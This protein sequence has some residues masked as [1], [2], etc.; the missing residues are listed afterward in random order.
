MQFANLILSLVMSSTL[1]ESQWP[2]KEFATR[3]I[4]VHL[5][6]SDSSGDK[7]SDVQTS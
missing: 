7:M 2:K 3:H 5:P 1:E 4:D 6:L